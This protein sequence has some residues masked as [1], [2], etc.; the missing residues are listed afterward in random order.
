MGYLGYVFLDA[1]HN[2]YVSGK[3]APDKSMREWEFNNDMQ[4][5]IKRRL[6][7]HSIYVFLTNPS[8]AKKNE[9]GRAHV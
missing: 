9:I 3:Q 4:Y 1:G 2:E 5:R 8:P 7:D 6:E